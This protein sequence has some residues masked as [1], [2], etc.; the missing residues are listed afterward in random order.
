MNTKIFKSIVTV[1]LLILAG[2]VGSAFGANYQYTFNYN[3][4]SAGANNTA[5]QSYM[6]NIVGAAGTVSL[7]GAKEANG[8]DGDGHVVGK[9]LG[10]DGVGT[11]RF[12]ISLQSGGTDTIK[13]QFTGLQLYS[14]TFD[15]E[16]FP[17]ASCTGPTNCPNLPDFNFY[18]G[19]GGTTSKI[20]Q[21]FGAFPPYGSDSRVSTNERS[22]QKVVLA[23]TYSS[24]TPF[25]TIWFQDWPATIGV[26]NI[27]VDGRT[28]PPQVPEPASIMLM[29]S[30]ALAL[31]RRKFKK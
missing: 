25:D 5:I 11:D 19:N 27:T 21:D 28:P 2:A 20:W 23:Y 13:M 6:Q 29:G 12:I 1:G 4:L 15:Y 22:A 16:I 9:T 10:Q 31:L 30:G 26:D 17:D 14:V 18:V 8:Y 3:S 7:S 24:A